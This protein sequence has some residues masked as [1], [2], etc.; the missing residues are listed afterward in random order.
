MNKEFTFN[1]TETYQETGNSLNKK[2]EPSVDTTSINTYWNTVLDNNDK[3]IKFYRN[4]NLLSN[5]L[6][7]NSLGLIEA[8]TVNQTNDVYVPLIGLI[9]NDTGSYFQTLD[10]DFTFFSFEQKIRTENVQLPTE[11][12]LVSARTWEAPKNNEID[13]LFYA[14]AFDGGAPI[15]H[16]EYSLNT[17]SAQPNFIRLENSN[18]IVNFQNAILT[19][20][21]TNFRYAFSFNPAT[22]QSISVTNRTFNLSIRAVNAKGTSRAQSVTITIGQN[23]QKSAGISNPVKQK[24]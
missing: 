19:T 12:Q 17:P 24:R 20:D 10:T 21:D 18:A 16:Y 15:T 14:P 23:A 11:P 9:A 3:A 1:S 2:N 7:R 13:V 8:N 6:T 22:I 4:I 5:D